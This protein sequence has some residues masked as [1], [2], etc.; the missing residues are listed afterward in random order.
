MRLRD[1]ARIRRVAGNLASYAFAACAVAA[2]APRV[3]QAPLHED[4]P[5]YWELVARLDLDRAVRAAQSRDEVSLAESLRRATGG[6]TVRAIDGLDSLARRT[7]TDSIVR[8]VSLVV[9]AGL[10]HTEHRW[11][12]LRA[13]PV[14]PGIKRD[15]ADLAGV[16]AWATAFAGA[17]EPRAR[18]RVDSAIFPIVLSPLGVPM[19]PVEINGRRFLFWLDTGASMTM[20]SDD[21]ARATGI[22]PRTTDSLEAVTAVGRLRVL[23]AMIDALH[24]GPL[25]WRNAPAMIVGNADFSVA[26]PAAPGHSSRA[27]IDGI[28]G[29]DVIRQLDIR[30]NHP[31]AVLTMR[32]P[33]RENLA[34][35][36]RNLFWLGYPMVRVTSANGATSIFGL[37]TGLQESFVTRTFAEIAGL[38]PVKVE[39]HRIAAIGSDSIVGGEILRDVLLNVG[40]SKLSMRSVTVRVPVIASFVVLD[41]VFGSDIGAAG[42]VR[43][44]ATNGVYE[45]RP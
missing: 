41:G 36:R 28:I 18:F 24:V 17:H 13:L 4:L 10:L 19:L 11:A 5:P 32:K 39:K 22:V 37:D 16:E 43:V 40:T 29:W 14:V 7:S 30:I 25:D 6:E 38:T 23:P 34:P 33:D 44:D 9:L 15:S 35:S 26:E 2:C 21:V 27:Q 12:E 31:G 1:R 45:V 3:R 42:V 20:I 8:G